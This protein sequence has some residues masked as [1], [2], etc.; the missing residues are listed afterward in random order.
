MTWR[1]L[2]WGHKAKRVW[3]TTLIICIRPNCTKAVI[4]KEG[5]AR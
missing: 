4:I 2:L 5:L 1:C 3:G